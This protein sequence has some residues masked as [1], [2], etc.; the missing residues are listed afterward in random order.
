M[1]AAFLTLMFVGPMSME[2]IDFTFCVFI[3]NKRLLNLMSLNSWP[4]LKF[5]LVNEKH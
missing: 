4:F 5:W 3:I 2:G 1:I